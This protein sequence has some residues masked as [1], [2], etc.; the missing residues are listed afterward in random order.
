M[1]IDF[2]ELKDLEGLE[3]IIRKEK[4]KGKKIVFTNGCFDILHSGHRYILTEASKY[5]DVVIVALN[6]DSSVKRLKGDDRPKNNELDRAYVISGFKGV[7]YV[8]IFGEDTPLNLLRRLQPDIVIKG[9]AA[10]PE[11]VEE[12]RQ[13]IEGYGGRIVNLPLVNGYS[14]TGIIAKIKSSG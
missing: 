13:I 10:I 4:I 1:E 6:S 5:G 3:K 7:D 11:R 2:K 12:E 8:I 9:G 14:T